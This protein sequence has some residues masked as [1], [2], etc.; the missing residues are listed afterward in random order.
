M[1]EG[2]KIAILIHVNSAV[3][4]GSQPAS[5]SGPMA[6]PGSGRPAAR[7]TIRAVRGTSPPV[8]AG[9]G[10]LF[11]PVGHSQRYDSG[12]YPRAGWGLG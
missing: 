3:A 5:E 4:A 11:A 10:D 7:G 8:R 9:E 1:A 12:A 2:S 6:G